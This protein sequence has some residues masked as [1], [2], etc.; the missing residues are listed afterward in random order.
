MCVNLMANKYIQYAVLMRAEVTADNT[1]ISVL[2]EWSHQDLLMCVESVRVDYQPE[3]GSLMMH[4]VDSATATSATFFCYEI[5]FML[6]QC[7]G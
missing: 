7:S 3:G 1:S 6:K 4:T 5:N 2:W